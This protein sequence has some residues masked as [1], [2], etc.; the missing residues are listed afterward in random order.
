MKVLIS[1]FNM[2]LSRFFFIFLVENIYLSFLKVTSLT[3]ATLLYVYF[4]KN[5]TKAKTQSYSTNF[6]FTITLF[7]ASVV[8]VTIVIV[9]SFVG[10]KASV[11]FGVTSYISVTS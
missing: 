2:F 9:A 10:F 5:K 1:F 8:H 3:Q 11:S 6:P 4:I 7:L